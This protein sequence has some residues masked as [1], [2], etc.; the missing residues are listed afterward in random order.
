MDDLLNGGGGLGLDLGLMLVLDRLTVGAAVQDLF[1]TFAWDESL[2]TYRPGRG[3]VRGRLLQAS[4]TRNSRS[5]TLPQ[6]R[7]S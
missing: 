7:R 4:R 3:V 1:H 2:L 6:A 5:R